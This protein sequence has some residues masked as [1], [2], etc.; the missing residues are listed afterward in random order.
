MKISLI[1]PTR[2]GISQDL[3]TNISNQWK[4]PDE[5]IEV[6]GEGLT[7]QR[8]EA[9]KQATGD[10]IVFIDD[11]IIMDRNFIS[12][13]S[14]FMIWNPK[15]MAVSGNPQ[16]KSYKPNILW[17]IYARIFMLTYRSNGRFLLSGFS[18]NYD[19]KIRNVIKSEVLHGCCMAISREIFWQY[20]FNENLVNR[21]YGEDD[22]FSNEIIQDYPIYYNPHAICYD[23]RPYR[24]GN[25][26]QKIRS[27]IINLI[28]RHR[29][30]KR[31]LLETLA[32][33]WAMIGFTIFKIVE[34]IIMLDIS[35]IWGLLLCFKQYEDKP[36][37]E[38]RKNIKINVYDSQWRLK[39]TK[40]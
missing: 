12:L 3:K 36:V 11:D 28:L 21:M 20:K 38:I 40:P 22:Y 25:Q 33:I 34:S 8:N 24:R 27:T 31:T 6:I 9:I 1:I 15:I 17:D 32:F 4:L 39:C 37:E 35:I 14:G 23:N 10:I 2:T 26:S 7:I 19:S 13:I 29:M 30:K 5:I 18:T 16:I